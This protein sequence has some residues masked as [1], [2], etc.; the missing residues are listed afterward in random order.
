MAVGNDLDATND[1]TLDSAPW[2]AVLCAVGGRGDSM[3][4]GLLYAAQVG[5][6]DFA[7]ATFIH[8]AIIRSADGNYVAVNTDG[9]TPGPYTFA[10]G[11]SRTGRQWTWPPWGRTTI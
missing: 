5:G 2:A 11:C 10:Q 9:T 4:A 7:A 6:T 8:E 1:G 3:A